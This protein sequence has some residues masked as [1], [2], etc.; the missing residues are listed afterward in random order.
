[1]NLL[2]ADGS[3]TGRAAANGS[4]EPTLVGSANTIRTV[5]GGTGYEILHP[6][7][8]YKLSGLDD[9]GARGTNESDARCN[10]T[11]EAEFPMWVCS[12]GSMSV[13]SF[14]SQPNNR[15]QTTARTRQP[16]S[17]CERDQRR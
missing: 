11:A 8:W 3:L 2:D 17:R 4:C 14:E 1:V 12:R 9:R 7:L 13:A 6:N 5:S 16:L 10:V 15:E